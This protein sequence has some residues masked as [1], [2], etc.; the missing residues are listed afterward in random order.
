[1]LIPIDLFVDIVQLAE[2]NLLCLLKSFGS[3]KPNL[4]VHCLGNIPLTVL[5]PGMSEKIIASIPK[6][7]ETVCHKII[8]TCD[9]G[10]QTCDGMLALVR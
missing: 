6:I 5:A 10:S 3:K 9:S 4:I 2:N 8:E 7:W 1:M